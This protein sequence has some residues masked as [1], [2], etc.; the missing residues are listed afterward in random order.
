V[1]KHRD[2]GGIAVIA[3]HGDLALAA[4]HVLELAA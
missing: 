4:P 3:T 1:S 2:G